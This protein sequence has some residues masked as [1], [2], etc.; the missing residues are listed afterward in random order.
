MSI[1]SLRASLEVFEKA[2][3]MAP[4]R[5]KSLLL[6]AYLEF[7][8]R[9]LLADEVRIITP[10][11]AS[12][13]GCQLSLVFAHGRAKELEH[14][15]AKHGVIVDS[16]EPDVIRVAPA[17]LYN[18]FHDVYTFVHRLKEVLAKLDKK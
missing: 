11:A 2:G 1:T 9:T 16:R 10:S 15:L 13:R 17:P 14:V 7:L 18:S 6:T 4:L 12:Q 8:L 3:G 5:A